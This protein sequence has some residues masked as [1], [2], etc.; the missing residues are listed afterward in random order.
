MAQCFQLLYSD[1]DPLDGTNRL[2]HSWTR[3]AIREVITKMS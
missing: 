3:Y 2:V 1:I